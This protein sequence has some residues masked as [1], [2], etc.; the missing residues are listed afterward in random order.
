MDPLDFAARP[1]FLAA[2]FLLWLAWDF[3]FLTIAWSIGWP[4]LRLLSFG[5]FPHVGL[6]EYE[7]SGTGEAFLVCGAGFCVLVA[8]V[9]LLSD[10]YGWQ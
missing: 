1:L 8:V 9:W 6:R 10:H 2:R 4:I 5:R 3:L 7:E